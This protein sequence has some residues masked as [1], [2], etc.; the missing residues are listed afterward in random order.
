MDRKKAGMADCFVGDDVVVGFGRLGPCGAACTAAPAAAG[1]CRG[2]TAGWVRITG[3]LLGDGCRESGN[4]Q[5]ESQ[6]FSHKVEFL[7]F[8]EEAE[9]KASE[10]LTGL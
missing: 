6:K 5:D 1:H 7:Y 10:G 9:I 2:I 8:M 3:S 4:N